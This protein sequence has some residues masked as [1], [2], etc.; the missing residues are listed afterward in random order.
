VQIKLLGRPAIRGSDGKRRV[1]RGQQVW[2]V[3]ARILLTPRPLDRRTLA[4][5][6]F[7]ETDDPLGALRWCLASLRRALDAPEAFA[8]DPVAANLPD[9]CRVDVFAWLEGSIDPDFSSNLLEGVEPRSSAQFATWLLVERARFAG[10]VDEAL[11]R[12][13]LGAL[14]ARDADRAA[15]LSERV[16]SRNPFD[17]GGHILLVQSLL[18]AGRRDAAVAHLEGVE[19]LFLADLGEMP[20]PA[21]RAVL[22]PKPAGAGPSGTSAAVGAMMDAGLAAVHAGAA[23]AGLDLLRQ[24]TSDADKLGDIALLAQTTVELGSALVHSVRGRDDEGAILLGEALMLARRSGQGRLAVRALRELGYVD[25]LAG[26]R[27]SAAEHLKA[28]RDASAPGEKIASILAITALNLVDW[29][30]IPEGLSLFEEA[31]D[32]AQAEEDVRTEIFALGLGSWGFLASERPE[33]ARDWASSCLDR[34]DKANWLAFRPFPAAMLGEA[35]LGLGEDPHE[36]RT[37]LE[38]A[39]ALGCQL[40]DPCWEGA[41]ARAIALSHAKGGDVQL[42]GEWIETALRRCTRETDIYMALLVQILDDQAK[43]FRIAG[44]MSQA[45]WKTRELLATAAKTHADHQISRA[46]AALSFSGKRPV[47]A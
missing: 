44:H 45:E 13:A 12:Q 10:L 3:L 24:A 34:A 31:L 29:G 4:L 21:L 26:R 17:E 35:R 15:R 23:D 27:P 20:S 6:V 30:R 47:G 41:T 5:D 8:G 36:L 16:V 42:A 38:V 32:T 39:F 11:R 43:F 37:D 1:L 28:A 33:A 25:S 7:P 40:R 22:K 18:L 9:G 2:A 14:Q 46:L 19:K